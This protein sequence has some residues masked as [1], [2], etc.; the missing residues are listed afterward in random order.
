MLLSTRTGLESFDPD[1]RSAMYLKWTIAFLFIGGFI[2]G[3]VMQQ[4]AFGALWTGFPF[5][6]DL[7][8]NKTLIAMLG[9]LFAWYKNRKGHQ[10][11]GW[12]LAASILLL[13][14]YLIP[15]SLLGSE[16]NYNAME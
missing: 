13:A 15:H 7:T 8:D 2:F 14:M 11:R 12:I 4:Y 6:H 10:G 5:G 3:P 16:L 9:W 1:G